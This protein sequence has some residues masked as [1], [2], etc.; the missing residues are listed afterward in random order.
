MNKHFIFHGAMFM[1]LAVALGAMASHGLQS[2]SEN[3]L[4]LF[5]LGVQYQIYHAIGLI[6][7]GIMIAQLPHPKLFFAGR[8]MFF[9][10]ILFSGGLYLYAITD[11]SPIKYIIPIGGL[12]L[13]GSWLGIIWSIFSHGKIEDKQSSEQDSKQD[14]G[15]GN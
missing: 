3:S 5:N 14:D 7:I 6:A 8:L 11:Y 4:R 2:L 15:E 10:I 1:A 13:I 12:F 9:G